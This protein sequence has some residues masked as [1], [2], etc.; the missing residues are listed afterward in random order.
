M[1]ENQI[2][3]SPLMGAPFV[4]TQIFSI[5]WLHAVDLGVAADFLGG[6]FATLVHGSL[7]GASRKARC[8]QL[9][10][11]VQEFYKAQ[12]VEDRLHGALALN[13]ARAQWLFAKLRCS[14]AQCRALVPFAQAAAAT[15]LGQG[16]MESTIKA[17]ASHLAE[18][19]Q[20]LHMDFGPPCG[21]PGSP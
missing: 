16:P 11:L 18:C 19:Y 14:A 8:A 6:L 10:A 13:A 17:A 12:K 5:D 4:T 15:W 2:P 21:P 20:A 9:W 1:L 7:P 3:L